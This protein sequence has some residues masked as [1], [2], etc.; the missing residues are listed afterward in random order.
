MPA[1]SASDRWRAMLRWLSWFHRWTGV[2][3]CLAFAV[4]FGSGLVMVFVPFPS[5][6]EQ[7]RLARSEVP[8]LAQVRVDP[9]AALQAAG[10]G[11]ELRLIAVAGHARYVVGRGRTQVAVDATSGKPAGP[12]DAPTAGAVAA[13]FAG[14]AADRV[15]AAFDYDQWVVHQKFD[16]WRPFYRVAIADA[17]RTQLYVSVRTGEIVQRTLAWERAW[18]WVGSVPHWL[19]FT[20]LR[21]RFAAWDW[22]V[23]CLAL[24]ALAGASAGTY[25]GLYRSYQRVAMRR[26]GWSPFKGCWRWHH[27][28]GLAA[29]PFVLT[30]IFSGWLS[31][32]HGRLFSRGIPDPAAAERYAGTSLQ[33]ALQPV[34]ATAL[35]TLQGSTELAFNVV[36]GHPVAVARTGSASRVEVLDGSAGNG[37]RSALPPGLIDAAVQRA[38]PQ[39]ARRSP[40]ARNDAL[41]RAADAIPADALR[42]GLSAPTGADLYIDA[43]SGRPLLQLD[44]SRRAYDWMYFALHTTRFPGLVEHPTLRRVLQVLPLLL[45][46]AFSMTGIVLGFRRL[47]TSW[48][49]SAVP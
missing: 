30:W 1:S 4:W 39:A 47:R 27:G 49:R 46:L 45:G 43:A 38:W 13:R 6:P 44:T 36:G 14:T 40:A 41:Y 32:D 9:A 15:S 33:R 16:A 29:A 19:Y 24:G 48:P 5:L 12:L 7:A 2:A 3:F 20:V 28:L 34:P 23:W 21:Q 26:P 25:L 11:S 17:P 42:Y 31:M 35:R 18:N 22:T 10:G 37:L 8:R